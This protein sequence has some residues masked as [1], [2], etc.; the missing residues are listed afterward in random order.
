MP[1]LPISLALREA[2]PE[3]VSDLYSRDVEGME[4]RDLDR[5]IAELRSNRTRL[6]AAEAA[7]VKPPKP[8][9]A[10]KKPPIVIQGLKL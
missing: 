8:P 1:I 7:G 4:R 6:E 5:V 2:A 10:D 9:R 3:S